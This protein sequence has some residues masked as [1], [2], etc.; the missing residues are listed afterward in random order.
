[1]DFAK[2]IEYIEYIGYKAII[3]AE[4][5]KLPEVFCDSD[6]IELY[7]IYL[8]ADVNYLVTK[9][10]AVLALAKQMLNIDK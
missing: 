7:D 8:D 9:I 1:M 10:N 4:Y 3:H 2:S 5:I 6:L